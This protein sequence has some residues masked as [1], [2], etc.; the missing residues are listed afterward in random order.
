MTSYPSYCAS[1]NVLGDVFT[2]YGPTDV[3]DVEG[4]GKL[5]VQ[6]CTGPLAAAVNVAP[7]PKDSTATIISLKPVD[8]TITCVISDGDQGFLSRSIKIGELLL[9]H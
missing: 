3:T 9:S 6:S 1:L 7:L 5:F 8:A 2:C 4:T